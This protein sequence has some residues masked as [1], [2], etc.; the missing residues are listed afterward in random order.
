MKIKYHYVIA[1]PH[2]TNIN[3]NINSTKNV[4]VTISVHVQSVKLYNNVLYNKNNKNI[5]V[6]PSK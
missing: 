6:A 4:C 5:F 3:L 1:A 2:N